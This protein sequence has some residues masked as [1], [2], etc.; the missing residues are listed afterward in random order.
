MY[1][2]DDSDVDFVEK[3]FKKRRPHPNYKEHCVLEK[4]FFAKGKKV[5]FIL[6][7]CIEHL[8]NYLTVGLKN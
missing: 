6:N 5:I 7:S 2:Q 4:E 1:L 3:D 8:L